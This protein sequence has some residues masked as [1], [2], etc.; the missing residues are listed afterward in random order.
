M[1]KLLFVALVAAGMTACMQSEELA[2][3]KSEAIAFGD[4][5]VYNASRAVTTTGNLEDF[6]VWAFMDSVAGTVLDG[7]IDT[8]IL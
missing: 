5:Y 2:V 6:D 1:K 7:E 3:P 4:A 8:I